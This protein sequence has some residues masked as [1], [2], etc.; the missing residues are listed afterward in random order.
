MQFFGKS[1]KLS[2][3]INNAESVLSKSKERSPRQA[4]VK[5]CAQDTGKNE[6]DVGR[7]EDQQS[8]DR[9]REVQTRGRW[10][11][12]V[13]VMSFFQEVQTCFQQWKNQMILCDL[14]FKENSG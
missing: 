11:E 13:K 8:W 14:S 10:Q 1:W 6:L 12:R 9:R 7:G 4:E 5:V 3:N 2:R